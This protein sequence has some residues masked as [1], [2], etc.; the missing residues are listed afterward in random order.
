METQNRT[1]TPRSCTF[2]MVD[3]IT[4]KTVKKV[5]NYQQNAHYA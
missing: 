2:N 4:V 1:V 3:L 5:K